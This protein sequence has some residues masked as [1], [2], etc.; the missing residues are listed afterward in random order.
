MLSEP[1]KNRGEGAQDRPRLVLVPAPLPV[2]NKT[3]LETDN[4]W[5]SQV[6]KLAKIWKDQNFD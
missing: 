3:Y 1:D 6:E 4:L 5:F 2:E